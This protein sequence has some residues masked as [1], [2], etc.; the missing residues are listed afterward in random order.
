MMDEPFDGLDL[1]QTREV[2]AHLRE[3][4]GNGRALLLSIHQLIDAE[5]MCDRFVL[6]S[7]G[8]VRGEGTIND[9]RAQAGMPD[10][11]LEELFLELS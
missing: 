8:Q 2:M 6:L 1:R 9:L 7:T 3:T 11:G 10:G 4:A 5:R